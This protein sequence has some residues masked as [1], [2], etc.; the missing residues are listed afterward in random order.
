MTEYEKFGFAVDML[1]EANEAFRKRDT[2]KDLFASMPPDVYAAEVATVSVNSNRRA[3]DTSYIFSR[4]TA[5]DLVVVGDRMLLGLYKGS[6]EV[7]VAGTP[8]PEKR[9]RRIYVDEPWRIFKS[10]S[11]R[12]AFYHAL[13]EDADQTFIFLGRN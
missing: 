5:E 4:A 8:L 12:E 10:T 13:C 11:E 1:V 3:G 7:R 9:Y 2:L 6:A